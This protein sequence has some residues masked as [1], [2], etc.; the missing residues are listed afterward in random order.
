MS[1]AAVRYS[2][3]SRR[4]LMKSPDE[5]AAED[6]VAQPDVAEPQE[7]EL[8]KPK[9]LPDPEP[10][11]EE[12]TTAVASA[13][14]SSAA[15]PEPEQAPPSTEQVAAAVASSEGQA[16]A[17]A[18]LAQATEALKAQRNNNKVFIVA[19]MGLTMLLAKVLLGI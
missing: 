13:A 12:L 3:A 2:R 5:I 19:S 8:P 10:A 14:A 1:K 11:A 7:P 15:A 6:A 9:L 4:G 18:L 16:S 17:E